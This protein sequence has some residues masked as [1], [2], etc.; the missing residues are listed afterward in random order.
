MALFLKNN[1]PRELHYLRVPN[2][3]KIHNIIILINIIATAEG[4]KVK[5]TL[6]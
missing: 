1:S 4:K 2:I 3:H 5:K 6:Q